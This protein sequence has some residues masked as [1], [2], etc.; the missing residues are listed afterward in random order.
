ML[1]LNYVTTNQSECPLADHIRVPRTLEDSSLP[2]VDE[3]H[4]L[5]ALSPPW[6]SLTGKA[7]KLIS[8]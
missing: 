5:E 8:F 4:S 6:H 7:I 2:T 1:T 3:I